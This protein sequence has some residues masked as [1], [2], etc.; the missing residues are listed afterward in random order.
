MCLSRAFL[1]F[2]SL[3]DALGGPSFT[4]ISGC[5]WVQPTG[6]LAGGRGWEASEVGVFIL[7]ASWLQGCGLAVAV[8][9]WGRAQ[10][11]GGSPLLELQLE[12]LDSY[13]CLQVPGPAPSLHPSGYAR[14]QLPA[15]ANPRG[16]HHPSWLPPILPYIRTAPSSHPS[17]NYPLKQMPLFLARTPTDNTTALCQYLCGL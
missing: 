12:L 16:L 3:C 14:P 8:F 6:A 11:F 7:L 5:S 13:S 15:V 17:L 10:F 1:P 2:S 9:L 4:C